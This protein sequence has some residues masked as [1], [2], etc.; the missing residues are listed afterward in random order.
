MA[1]EGNQMISTVNNVLKVRPCLMQE[2]LHEIA[3]KYFGLEINREKKLTENDSYD[4]RC[5]TVHGKFFKN[6]DI[7]ISAIRRK[8][9]WKFL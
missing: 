7:I 4:D 8:K 3:M 2:Q 5:F 1:G 9:T 6:N